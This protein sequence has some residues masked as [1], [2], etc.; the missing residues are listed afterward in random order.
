MVKGTSKMNQEHLTGPES[1]GE[2]ENKLTKKGHSGRGV[3]GTQE[4]ARR[5]P[6]AKAGKV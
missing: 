2:P 6:V 4:P 3:K 5:D 1:R